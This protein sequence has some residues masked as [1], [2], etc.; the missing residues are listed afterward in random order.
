M[1]NQNQIPLLAY[2]D[3]TIIPAKI[4]G[5][6]SRSECNPY[7]PTETLPI[8]TAPMS[9]IV[10]AD[11]FKEWRKNN[12][13]PIAPR[14]IEWETRLNLLRNGEW[15][16]VG[17]GGFKAH[18]IEYPISTTDRMKVCIDIANGHMQEVLELV[19]KAKEINPGLVIMAGNIANPMTIQD[20]CEAGV[21]FVRVGIGGGSG[22]ITSSN[23]GVHFPMASL[24]SEC[25]KTRDEWERRKRLQGTKIIADG[26]IRGYGDVNKALSLGADRVMIGGLFAGCLEASGELS[27]DR[28]GTFLEKGSRENFIYESG[29]FYDKKKTKKSSPVKLYHQFYG[30][31]SRKGQ[32]DI[33]GG[34][35]EKTAEGIEKTIP[36]TITLSGWVENMTH[37]LRSSMSYIGARK[38]EEIYPMSDVKWITP[39]S[40]VSINP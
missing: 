34:I 15:I 28:D 13:I 29:K 3:V 9:S 2:R 37:Y 26:G 30:M 11:N 8:F 5:V 25:R 6:L 32:R 21:D 27:V 4:T 19:K 18:F 38:L 16:A 17:L 20:Y 35:A 10:D 39:G 33:N 31:A 40:Y 23:T 7:L 22:C 36:V 1:L 14:N 24:I 12:I